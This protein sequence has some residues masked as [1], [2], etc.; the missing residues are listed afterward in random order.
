[1]LAPM[2]N[3]QETPAPRD[4]YAFDDTA[5]G[6]IAQ[7]LSIGVLTALPDYF[8]GKASLLAAYAVAVAGFG[9]L[10]GFANARREDAEPDAGT[11]G[12]A[13]AP[14]SWALLAAVLALL[15]FSSWAQVALSRRMAKALVKRGVAKPWTVL[16]AVG[17]ALTWVLSELQAREKASLAG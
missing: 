3:Q 11:V 5:A 10:V 15:F 13:P 16:G 1:M 6:R 12:T 2:I 4:N 7:A 17:A 14:R 8:R 9:A